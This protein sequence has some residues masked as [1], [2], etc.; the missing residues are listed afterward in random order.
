M[1]QADAQRRERRSGQALRR[2][3]LW[4]MRVI[5]VVVLLAS[6]LVLLTVNKR[7]SPPDW[8]RARA[9]ARIEQ[10]LDGLQIK[11]GDIELV[12][13]DGL[14]PRMHLRDVVLSEPDGRILARL[15]DAQA[16]LA[17]RPLLRGEVQPKRIALSGLFATLRRDTEGAVSL[18]L[19][20]PTAPVGQAAGVPQ[21]LARAEQLLQRP[22][23]SALVAV[24]VDS[25][26]M[27]Y[28]DARIGQG[29]TLDGGQVRLKRRGDDL[30]VSA[31]FA[32]LSGRDYASS[33]E[34]NYTSQIGEPQADFGVSVQDIAASDIAAQ[35]VAL[36]WLTV[37][38]A[39]ISGALRGGIDATGA[40]GPLSATLQIGAGALQP[41]EATLPIPFSGA[42]SYFTYD[43]V[44][45]TL[46]FDEMSVDSD[47]GAGR[48]EGR[49][50][51]RGI[52]N[53]TLTDLVGQFTFA[54]TRLNPA[55]LYAEPLQLEGGSADF[56][57]ELDPFRLT[58]GQMHVNERDS[59]FDFSGQ[60]TAAETGW[61]LALDAKLDQL[62]PA[63]LMELWP[64]AVAEKPRLWVEQNIL[65]GK[66]RDL[67]LA[68]R[69]N[70]GEKPDIYA[71]LEFE[72]VS[73]RYNRYLPLLTDAAGVLTLDRGRLVASAD[74][75][76]VTAAEGGDLD[77]SG[78]SFVIPDISVKP[79]TPAVIRLRGAGQVTAAMSLLAGPPVRAL[80]ATDLPVDL[81]QG[82]VKLDGT[83]S[84]PLE[85]GVP[86]ED[87]AF[88][89][90][91][92]LSDVESSVLV[93]GQTVSASALRLKADQTQV[94]IDGT[95]HIGALPVVL[96]WRQPIG[97]GAAKGSR[98]KGQVELS[99]TLIDTFELGLPEGSV[100]G[101]GT[102]SFTLD[103][104]SGTPPA[105]R[106]SSDL[107]GVGLSIPTL[108]W[109]KPAAGTGRFELSGVLGETARIE[110]LAI[111]AAG[112][113]A[114]GSVISRKG[115][116][117][118]RALFSSVRLGGWL[119]AGVELTGRGKAAPDVR[120]LT[121][122]LDL[123]RAPLDGGGEGG[124]ALTVRLDRLQVT[125]GLALHDFA[126]DFTTSD[127]LRGPFTGTL[128]GQ[129]P[130][131]GRIEPR[132][133]G[134][135]IFVQSDD[136]G[137]VFRSAGILT[138]GH[139]GAFEM[140]LLPAKAPALFNGTLRVKNT[141]VKDAPAIAAL[142]NAVSVVGLLDE[143]S[144]QGIQ[145]SQ[146]EA[147]FRLEPDRL[148][149]LES[150]ATGPSIGLSMDGLYDLER[151]VLNMRGVVSPVY[152]INAVGSILTRKG[153]GMIGFSY[154]LKGPSS[155]PVVQVNPL[156]G[157]APGLFREI[158]RGATPTMPGD[159]PE[160]P[161]RTPRHTNDL[162]NGAE[163]GR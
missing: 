158:F 88:H 105:L 12:I 9:E 138:Q 104:G 99:Q 85:K 136:G 137:G 103:L 125:E 74:R 149:L 139:G 36:R 98:V 50:Y 120:I 45:Q 83:L 89:F 39:P 151:G 108:G 54:A 58:L 161:D 109:R 72:Q 33:V 81:A 46:T 37:L 15:S 129:T 123:R 112:L 51:L 150:S 35:S 52:E 34:M 117:L 140:T 42:R 10:G 30:D 141:R 102:G 53:G 32:L 41:T 65:T 162:I 55:G 82:Q 66:M 19:G 2:A 110:H 80:R 156:S 25:V 153:E 48:S 86:F 43:P 28:E 133:G 13:R 24:D 163:G 22:Q 126:G 130:V 61:K 14:R 16:S 122:V 101:Q 131:R 3:G 73:L 60:L 26:T 148:V 157:L 49:A 107:R 18:T 127:G 100:S 44:A 31:D 70:E 154:T 90:A 76:I 152:L 121:G 155:K 114:T 145:F 23:F 144:G 38:R 79:A 29:W 6:L 146:V 75:G 147:R 27:R 93:P 69:L 160:E 17:M 116:G 1:T 84:L 57:L 135:A 134:S 132:A 40:L 11:F 56:R 68:L 124:G 143:M 78:S 95:A 94:Q 20:D 77:I 118:D 111:D 92:E 159:E 96:G 67:D 5:A 142:L 64:A 113:K 128:N 4:A 7:L 8:L 87:I 47:W 63:R 115:G 71:D 106:L 62:T 59:A 97:P 91:G 21:L 119:E